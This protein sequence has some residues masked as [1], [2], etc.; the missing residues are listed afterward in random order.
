MKGEIMK[1]QS[2]KIIKI[3]IVEGEEGLQE[4][5]NSKAKTWATCQMKYKYKYEDKLRPKRTA[6]PLRKGSWVHKVLEDYDSGKNWVDT[7]KTLR[8]TEYNKLFDEE[9]ALLGD[10]PMEVFRMMRAYF[11]T[12]KEIDALHEV[13]QVEQDFMIRLPGTKIVLTGKIDKITRDQSGKVWIWEHKT[14]KS[15]PPS[16]TFR[17]TD[18]QTAMYTWVGEQLAPY[19]GYNKEDIAGIIFDYI[20]TKPPTIPEKLQK[21]ETS[22]RKIDCDWYTY[23][24]TVKAHGNDPED[25]L[26]MKEKLKDSTFFIRHYMA[27]SKVMVRN[28]LQNMVNT[29]TQIQTLSPLHVVANLNWTC[30]RPR[31]D[32]RDLCMADLMGH[33]T[34]SMIKILYK[35]EEEEENESREEESID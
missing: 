29:G 24:A 6:V 14:M 5:S 30:D 22:R 26:D 15:A 32:Y 1:N 25:Y 3:G 33:D 20:K 10:L 9:K 12:Y 28:I 2:S 34:S 21:G 13:I 7:I 4:L 35:Q 23:A 8:D 16:E 27:K 11:Q 17:M 19:L 18:T 31:C